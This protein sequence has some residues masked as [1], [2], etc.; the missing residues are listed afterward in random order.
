MGATVTA[1]LDQQAFRQYVQADGGDVD[2]FTRAAAEAVADT[3]RRLAPR[4]S[5]ELARRIDVEQNRQAGRFAPGWSVVCDAPY[6]LFVHEGTRPHPIVARRAPLLVFYWERVG[7]VVA[8][9]RVNHPGT[10]AQPF[11]ADALR[12]TSL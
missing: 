2:R 3:A 4:R 5:G 6:A 9:P 10:R 1:E 8:F 7:A 12:A 11:L